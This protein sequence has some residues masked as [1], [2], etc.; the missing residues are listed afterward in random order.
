MM[1][2]IA[3]PFGIAGSG[4]DVVVRAKIVR[5][6]GLVAAARYRGCAESHLGRELDSEMAQAAQAKDGHQVARLSV[7]AAER[8]EDRDAG[9]G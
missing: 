5:K 6:T 7:A 8:V 4:V 2:D 3:G 9:A 1:A